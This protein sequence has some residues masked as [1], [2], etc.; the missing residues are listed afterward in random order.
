MILDLVRTNNTRYD[1]ILNHMKAYFQTHCSFQQG[2]LCLVCTQAI[3]KFQ[4][5]AT[6]EFHCLCILGF[7]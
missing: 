2:S 6:N 4:C 7:G 5:F 3:N 1:F